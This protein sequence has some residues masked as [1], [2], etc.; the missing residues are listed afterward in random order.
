M[1]WN[2]VYEADELGAIIKLSALFERK[3]KVCVENKNRNP[4]CGRRTEQ[5]L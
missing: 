3:R 1:M 5:H 2:G 4:F